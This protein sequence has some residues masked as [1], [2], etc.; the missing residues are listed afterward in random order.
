[1]YL[2]VFDLKSVSREKH[3]QRCETEKPERGARMQPTAQAVGLHSKNNQSPS[4]AKE[5]SLQVIVAERTV[6]ARFV[7]K[8]LS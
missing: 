1:M 2:V 5:T 3:S 4:G 7:R 8:R 6:P